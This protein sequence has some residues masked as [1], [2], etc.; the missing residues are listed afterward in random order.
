MSASGLCSISALREHIFFTSNVVNVKSTVGDPQ[1]TVADQLLDKLVN[2]GV[3]VGGEL[4][5]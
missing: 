4:H 1:S 2:L 5:F 3:L